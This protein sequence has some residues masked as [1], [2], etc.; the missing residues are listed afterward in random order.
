VDNY[1]DDTPPFDAGF[2]C[3][4]CGGEDG[5]HFDYCYEMASVMETSDDVD[6]V[7]YILGLSDCE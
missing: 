6:F 1:A 4:K 2:S 5:F 3:E 7:L